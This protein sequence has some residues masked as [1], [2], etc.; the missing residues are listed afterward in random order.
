M[1][2]ILIA[3]CAALALS[4]CLTAEEM[5]AQRAE[6]KAR[7]ARGGDSPRAPEGA[8]ARET[9]GQRQFS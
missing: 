1:F 8:G 5:A 3:G 2:K 9:P 6:F 4:G 7:V